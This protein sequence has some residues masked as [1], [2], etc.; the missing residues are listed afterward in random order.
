[1]YRITKFMAALSAGAALLA[2]GVA[3]AD[4]V[5]QD[6]Q[7][8][9]VVPSGSFYVKPV[10]GWPAG[11]MNLNYDDASQKI[12]DPAP[13]WLR[14]MNNLQAGREGKINASL[15][16]PAVL[17]DGTP[18]DDLPLKVFMSSDS[19]KTAVPLSTTA[20]IVYDNTSGAQE[21]G[22]LQIQVDQTNAAKAGQ[23]YNGVVSLIFESAA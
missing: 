2:A 15:A 14:M 12:Q 19:V 6:I 16:Y 1:M 21:T 18:A 3:H 10:G 23:T 13:I 8:R 17:T 4:Q 20:Q 5:T 22:K 9:A 7:L 11:T